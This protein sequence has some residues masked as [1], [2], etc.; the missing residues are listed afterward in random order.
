MSNFGKS[1]E[2]FKHKSEV[3]AGHC[4]DVGRDF[5]EIGRTV[6]LMSIIGSDRADLDRKLEVAAR[7][8]GTSAEEFEAEHLVGTI[9]EICEI[10]GAYAEAGCAELILYFYD[11]GEGDSQ[12]MFA[13]EV[14]PYFRDS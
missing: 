13:S 12:D 10:V 3:L 9:E 8:R 14:M 7:R 4:E 11:M 2:E 6:H 5:G 1:V